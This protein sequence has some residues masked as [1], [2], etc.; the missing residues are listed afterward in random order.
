MKQTQK[1]STRSLGGD[2]LGYKEIVEQYEYSPL[3][4]PIRD[5]Q[6]DPS[7]PTL[8]ELSQSILGRKR[9]RDEPIEPPHVSRD[10]FQE[11]LAASFVNKKDMD[12]NRCMTVEGDGSVKYQFFHMAGGKVQGHEPIYTAC[13]NYKDLK[14]E[15][16]MF[17]FAAQEALKLYPEVALKSLT[18][19]IDGML[20]RKV[21][22]GVLYD[23][24]TTKQKKSILFSS[25]IIKEKYDLDGKFITVKSRIVTGGDGQ[26]LEDI[27]E[28]LRSAQTTATSSVST[29]A[30]KAAANNM[31]IATVD[32]KQ[33]Y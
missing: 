33:A 3:R 4:T 12:I 17:S 19:E 13:L 16:E 2:I 5:P 31:E 28:R 29:I 20:D 14:C 24:L 6:I 26:N 21:W 8:G 22:N 23:S 1:I 32:I 27:P 25:T 7:S 10:I 11:E 30:S 15:G 18:D 9:G